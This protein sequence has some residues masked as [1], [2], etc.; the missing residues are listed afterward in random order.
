VKTDKLRNLKKKKEEEEAEERDINMLKQHQ[1]LSD[2]DIDT[3]LL[4]THLWS[5]NGPLL[6]ILIIFLYFAGERRIG[7][8]G[9]H[10]FLLF[11]LF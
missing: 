10:E 5:Q 4:S 3:C 2:F 1:I 9:F 8:D 7:W 6:L 11:L